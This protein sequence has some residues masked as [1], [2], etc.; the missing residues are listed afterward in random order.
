M[1]PTSFGLTA[2]HFSGVMVAILFWN[3]YILDFLW[4]LRVCTIT[5]I[6]IKIRAMC[7][8]P[9]QSAALDFWNDVQRMAVHFVLFVVVTR[10]SFTKGSN[11]FSSPGKCPIAIG[12]LS[13]TCAV[14]QTSHGLY[15]RFCNLYYSG[16]QEGGLQWPYDLNMNLWFF[17]KFKQ[18]QSPKGHDF[19]W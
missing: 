13:K 10:W 19:C 8:V 15:G 1:H 7:L 4:S 3:I 18:I 5:Y 14:T 9:I 11:R 2:I 12:H 17:Q 16:S 6:S